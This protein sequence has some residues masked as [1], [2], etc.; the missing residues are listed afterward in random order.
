M[1]QWLPCCRADDLWQ[2]AL[3]RARQSPS[4]KVPARLRPIASKSA[5]QEK[6]LQCMGALGR[7]LLPM[8]TSQSLAFTS[9]IEFCL[10]AMGNTYSLKLGTHYTMYWTICYESNRN[11]KSSTSYMRNMRAHAVVWS[12]VH[13][14]QSHDDVNDIIRLA[15]RHQDI[16]PDRGYT[17]CLRTIPMSASRDIVDDIGIV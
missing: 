11:D 8:A 17:L 14:D 6:L 9:Y 2:R 12:P 5:I 16:V 13:A 4:E 7:S 15:V 1:L 3:E 10:V